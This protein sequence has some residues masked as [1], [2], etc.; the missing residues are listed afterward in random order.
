ME[1]A[2]GESFAALLRRYRNGAGLTQEELAGRAGLSA[3]TIA[4]LERRESQAPQR[5]TVELL[6]E[7]LRLSER[8]HAAFKLAGRRPAATAKA[9][10]AQQDKLP[11]PL[12]SFVGREGLIE[13][14]QSTLRAEARL[15]TL[16]GAGGVGKTRLALRAARNLVGQYRDGACFVDL[17]AT[18]DPLLVPST[19]ARALGVMESG[20]RPMLD[21]LEGYLQGKQMLLVLDNF[22]Q[23]VG[24]A[25]VVTRLLAAAPKLKILITSR[26]PLH[27]RG[28]REYLV[29]PLALPSPL[30]RAGPETLSRYAAVDLFI[31]RARDA[32]PDFALTSE[33]APAVAEICARLDG[34]PLAIELG[35][36]RI[37]L[38]SPQVMLSRVQNQL[39]LLTGGARDLPKRQRTMRSTIAWSYDLLSDQ[40]KRLYR[41]L[42]VF[43]GGFTLEAAEAVCGDDEPDVL[44][45][46]SGLVDSSLVRRDAGN[47]TETR[48]RMLETVRVFAVER[49]EESGEAEGMRRRHAEYFLALTEEAEPELRGARQV[50]WLDRLEADHDNL[51]MALSWALGGGDGELGL[52]LGGALWYFWFMRGHW[53]EGR[54]T[55]EDALALAVGTGTPQA[56]RANVLLGLGFLAFWQND[57]ERAGICLQDSLALYRGLG[58]KRGISAALSFLAY[59]VSDQG[60]W[61]AAGELWRE[62][63]ALARDAK[64]ER[65]I[66]RDLLFLGAHAQAQG[67]FGQAAQ[68][69][70][71]CEEL[72]RTLGDKTG[73]ANLLLSWGWLQLIQ[74][75]HGG[76]RERLEESL[77]IAQE[78]GD[79]MVTSWSLSN[80]GIIALELGDHARAGTLMREALKLFWRLGDRYGVSVGLAEFGGLAAAEGRGEAAA[81]LLGAADAV[82]ERIG[83]QVAPNQQS[84]ADRCAA[85]ARSLLSEAAFEAAWA[86]GRAMGTEEAI[87]YALACNE[88]D[89]AELTSGG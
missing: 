88:L 46:L 21:T 10:D 42:G 54:R 67:D 14:I 9:P 48:F 8:E 81:R 29:P 7:A 11:S 51:R 60:N 50:E 27:V 56:S 72:M 45:R 44:D 16:T 66:T 89:T 17:S 39:G 3:R 12:T 43:A 58:D 79:T 53:S 75:D 38:L 47:H 40:E 65:A 70:S 63:L 15:L 18:A 20:S 34:L 36:A 33:N 35:A 62:S 41:R 87:T 83:A 78:I 49:L 69:Y 77:G 19:V 32:R 52:Q 59:N 86:E 24:A 25:P 57:Y 1:T 13:Q 61:D 68:M 6:A 30:E 28:E 4:Y 71:E 55:L 80:L 5:E 22:E 85:A 31:Q 73:F 2:T 82:R 74:G 76:A 84:F 64:D 37:R 26:A 23:V